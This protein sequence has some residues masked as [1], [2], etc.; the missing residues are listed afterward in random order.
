MNL[1]G[2]PFE[3][4]DD[5]YVKQYNALAAITKGGVGPSQILWMSVLFTFF[6]LVVDWVQAN[7]KEGEPR[8][9][10]PNPFDLDAR[11]HI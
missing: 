8:M 5:E 2:T 10:Q 4:Y 7:Q 9:A 1:Q 3:N 11:T 6:K